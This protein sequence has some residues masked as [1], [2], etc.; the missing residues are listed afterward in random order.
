MGRTI[1]RKIVT[2]PTCGATHK[3]VRNKQ[4]RDKPQKFMRCSTCKTVW[5]EKED[6]QEQEQQQKTNSGHTVTRTEKPVTKTDKPVTK[7]DKPV[8]KTE[9]PVPKKSFWDKL[10]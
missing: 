6:V 8:T 1:I 7:T 4:Y 2:C 5:T 3:V 10:F 9:K